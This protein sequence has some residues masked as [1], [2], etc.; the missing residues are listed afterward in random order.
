MDSFYHIEKAITIQTTIVMRI[1]NCSLCDSNE[2]G[3]DEPNGAA[4]ACIRAD[5]FA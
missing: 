1:T 2:P 4:D 5:T 3:V